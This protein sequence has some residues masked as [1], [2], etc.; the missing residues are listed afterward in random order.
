VLCL[1]LI[2][3]SAV[4]KQITKGTKLITA[5]C[6]WLLS[7]FWQMWFSFLCTPPSILCYVYLFISSFFMTDICPGRPLFY[8]YNLI[9]VY[10]FI[11][12]QNVTE[13]RFLLSL[14]WYITI[15]EY[16]NVGTMLYLCLLFLEKDNGI[17]SFILLFVFLFLVTAGV[18]LR[19]GWTRI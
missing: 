17:S 18:A 8:R 4:T 15:L 19:T 6:P 5:P 10:V 9:S 7:I 16:C 12:T 1:V 14:Y 3:N 13:K 2:C 11:F